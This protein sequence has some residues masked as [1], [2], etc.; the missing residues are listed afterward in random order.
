MSSSINSN[1][2]ESIKKRCRPFD[3]NLTRQLKV[4]VG[5]KE[6]ADKDEKE[7]ELQKIYGKEVIMILL[8]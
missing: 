7:K 1:N 2:E 5:L 8:K 4:H 3:E 6:S